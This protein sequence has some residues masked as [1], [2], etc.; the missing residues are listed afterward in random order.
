[1][2]EIIRLG[3]GLLK[4]AHQ[5]QLDG[6]RMMIVNPENKAIKEIV[7]PGKAVSIVNPNKKYTY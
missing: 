4:I 1:M 3:V 7:L 2:E 5:S 6:N